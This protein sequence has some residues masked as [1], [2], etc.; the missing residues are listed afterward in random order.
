MKN[1]TGVTSRALLAAAA[2]LLL[3]SCPLPYDYNGR[4]AGSSNTTDP[5][6]PKVTAAV[7]VSYAEQGGTSGTVADKDTYTTGKTVT[8]TLSTTTSNATIYY[9]DDGQPITDINAVKKFSGSRGSITLTRATTL[10]TLALSAVAIGPNMVPST[11]ISAKVIVSPYP[12]LSVSVDRASFSEDGETATFTITSSVIPTT[13]ISFTVSATGS[14]T[15]A[16]VVTTG[17]PPFPPAVPL[18][19]VA[20]TTTVQVQVT[21]THNPQHVT[22]T[23]ILTVDP[24]TNAPPV[25]PA[26]SPGASAT[27]TIQDDGKYAVTYLPSG[28]SGTPPATV[29]YAPSA[30]VTVQG[31]GTLTRAGF[32]FGGWA[33]VNGVAYPVGQMFQMPNTALDLYAV[34]T[35]LPQVSTPLMSPAAGNYAS[36]V[37]VTISC[38]T[39]GATIRYTTDGTVPSETNGTIFPGTPITVSSVTVLRAIA[40]EVG[41]VDSPIALASYVIPSTLAGP[42]TLTNQQG[43][44]LG[45]FNL[46]QITSD[47]FHFINNSGYVWSGTYQVVGSQLLEITS[48]AI[49]FSGIVWNIDNP[50]HITQV[51]GDVTTTIYIGSTMTR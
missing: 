39:P 33:D 25:P 37:S 41:W 32:T 19:M 12:I 10:Q 13:N 21:A 23:I 2:V 28:G 43:T 15:T 22:H 27:T 9:R 1:V 36:P 35:P 34:W 50:S 45:T 17:N 38:A 7:T 18:T 30:T 11:P 14:Y 26:Y 40:Y 31:A 49:G 24:D 46:T 5:S 51:G 16:D 48:D 4:G 47:T 42:W 20:G 44:N 3:V 8:V 29:N 6:S